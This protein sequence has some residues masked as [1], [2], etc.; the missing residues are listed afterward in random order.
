MGWMRRLRLLLGRTA[1]SRLYRSSSEF[2]LRTAKTT[3]A[4]VLSYVV[5]ERLKTSPQPVLAPLTAL[6]VVQLTLY[7]TVE[8][9]LERILSVV[10]GVLVALGVATFVGL[11]WWSLGALIAV[12]L[13]VGELVR[14]GPH[15]LEVPITAMLILAVSGAQEAA[16]GRVYETLIG[17]AGGVLVNVVIAPPL[18]I[19]PASEAIGEL[20][21]RMAVFLRGLAEQLRS[22]WSREAAERWL[23]ESRALA[24]DVQRADQSVARAEQSARLN[25]RGAVAREA[26]PRLRT[27]LT[28]LEHC[29]VSL[30]HLTR[31]LYDHTCTVAGE[32]GVEAYEPEVREVLADILERAA[33]ALG[34]V[35]VIA[36]GAGPAE[37]ARERVEARL[38]EMHRLR[39][40]LSGLLLV[41]PHTDQGAW[42]QHGAL[43]A[44]IDR[45][46][47]EVEAAVRPP[48]APWRSRLGVERQRQA[49]RLVIDAAS[50]AAG[51]LRPI[52]PKVRL[53]HRSG[54]RL[55]PGGWTLRRPEKVGSAG[56]GGHG[57][58]RRRPVREAVARWAGPRRM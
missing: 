38:S 3:L 26:Q 13:V 14:L 34:S 41:D 27:A 39:H 44:A 45:V 29:Y 54:W 10:S 12:S 23:D 56:A 48:R 4:A 21:N 9:G 11:T 16:I 1:W 20:A 17:A 32:D 49:A 50:Q 31:A 36:C 5:A 43:L 2:G 15:L 55:A 40:R 33:E 18:Y 53:V 51:E 42:Q 52:L 19:R 24:R 58:H 8:H 35:I 47:V 28:G 57:Q 6:L 46:R 25:P 37:A 30:R 22:G 7:E